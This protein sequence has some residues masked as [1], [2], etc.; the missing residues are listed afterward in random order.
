MAAIEHLSKLK[1]ITMRK[2][3]LL[4]AALF[5]STL[6][7]AQIAKG[8]IQLGG[9]ISWNQFDNGFESSELT[10]LPSAGLFVSP[11]TSIGLNLGVSRFKNPIFD[12]QTGNIVD[13]TDR[14]FLIG[15]FA[16]F[17]KPISDNFY[18]FLQPSVALGFGNQE[19]GDVETADINS[20][21]VS[22]AP[23]LTYFLSPKFALE[24]SVNA[25]NYSKIDFEGPQI[26]QELENYGIDL[27]LSNINLG[28]NFYIK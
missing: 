15:A 13:G 16:R 22:I 10:I 5:V 27:D 3:I 17:H 19:V 18:L 14:Q 11:T 1:I 25:F 4:S 6:S 23:G 20:F 21:G 12:Q 7:F 9:T 8:D 24:M 2:L 26:T 28:L